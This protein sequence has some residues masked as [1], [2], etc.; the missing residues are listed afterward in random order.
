M[1]QVV[2]CLIAPYN[3][4]DEGKEYRT[5]KL[6]GQEINLITSAIARMNMFLHGI[7]DF[8]IMRGDTLRNPAFT[9][10]DELKKFN[11]ILANPPYSSKSWDQKG[12]ERDPYGRN[13]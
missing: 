3:L 8:S 7:E 6:Y 12:F 10:G 5:L 4:K 2:Y 13:I 11:I 1:V 9:K